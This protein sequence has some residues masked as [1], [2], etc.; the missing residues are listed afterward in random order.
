MCYNETSCQSIDIILAMWTL[1]SVFHVWF[2][3]IAWQFPWYHQF[4]DIL[5]LYV[6]IVQ[7]KGVSTILSTLQNSTRV[8]NLYGITEVSSWSTCCEIAEEDLTKW[9]SG[10]SSLGSQMSAGGPSDAVCIGVPLLNTRVE[11]V[12]AGRGRLSAEQPGE[13]NIWLGGCGRVCLL[14]EDEVDLNLMRP[15]GD[16]GVVDAR[17]RVYCLGRCDFQVKRFGHR[18][19]LESMEQVSNARMA[20]AVR[21]RWQDACCRANVHCRIH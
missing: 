15:S 18:V 13:G 21:Q 6:C 5:P 11:V 19:N 16:V 20:A 12:G 4:S 8:F 17:G 14:K 1:S 9:R 3:S 7:C 10:P 2:T